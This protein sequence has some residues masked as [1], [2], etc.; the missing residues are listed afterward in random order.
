MR[1]L[2]AA[3]SLQFAAVSAA[4]ADVGCS[5][6]TSPADH[7]APLTVAAAGLFVGVLLLR[8]RR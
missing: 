4:L 7:A 2:V 6:A 3:V 1:R 5:H 8:R